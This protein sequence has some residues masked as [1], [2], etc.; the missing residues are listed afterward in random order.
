MLFQDVIG[1]QHIKAR[2]LASIQSHKMSHAQLFSSKPGGGGLPLALAY[3][4]YV[5]CQNPDPNDSCGVCSS[6]L[7]VQKLVHPDLHFT[8]PVNTNESV[9]KDPLSDK[10]LELWRSVVI[11]NP[12]LG[13]G[14]WI[15][16][17]DIENKQAII[18]AEECSVIR[19][20]LELKSY[21]ANYK[22][23]IIWMPERLYHAAAPKLLKILE[24]PPE[25]TL[26]LLVSEQ[27]DLLLSTIL[28]RLQIIKLSPLSPSEIQEALLKKEP[29]IAGRVDLSYI[30]K[31]AEGNYSKALSWAHENGDDFEAVFL[32]WM[33]WCFVIHKDDTILAVQSWIDE[34]SKNSKD[35]LK[36]Y[37]GHCLF[38]TSQCLKMNYQ[39]PELVMLPQKSLS[40]I[41]KFAPFINSKN[42]LH[43]ENAFEKAIFHIER[44]V[45]VKMIFLDLSL[46]LSK[47]IRE[48]ESV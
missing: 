12:Y 9:K 7:K 42:I 23:M 21:E 38:I 28:S 40:S 27:M 31:I 24:E 34:I 19:E 10:F 47:L 20:K 41:E 8:F 1:Q 45:N 29:E 4:Q 36:S 3:A 16:A 32:Q 46:Q 11:E 6:C 39:L 37:L 25:K 14:D 13:Y 44:N 26:F 18:N 22:I 15:S 2:L 17:L 5:L 48:K 35:Y 43:I 33:R 30:S